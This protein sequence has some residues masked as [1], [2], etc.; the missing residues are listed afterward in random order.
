MILYFTPHSLPTSI[1][2]R[3]QLFDLFYQRVMNTQ[4][5]SC[6]IH[7][8]II[9]RKHRICERHETEAN[10]L[11]IHNLTEYFQ[12]GIQLVTGSVVNRPVEFDQS[13][14]FRAKAEEKQFFL[15]SSGGTLDYETVCS[16][17]LDYQGQHHQKNNRHDD[18]P[19]D[20]SR[21]WRSR[22]S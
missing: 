2:F 6:Y 21:T 19:G 20:D 14:L 12:S 16:L 11:F 4:C 18:N 22:N 10:I 15:C 13:R 5:L 8:G 3:Q 17:E 9:S 7:H 1:G